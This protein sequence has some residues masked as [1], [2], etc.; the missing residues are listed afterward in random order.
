MKECGLM[1]LDM[2]KDMKG[3]QTITHILVCIPM[4]KHTERVYTLGIMDKYMMENGMKELN[5]VTEY[6]KV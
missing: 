1:M 2:A 4:V 3:F 5:M 6:G